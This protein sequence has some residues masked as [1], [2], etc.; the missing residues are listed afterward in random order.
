MIN[1]EES[2]T[3]KQDNSL[4][5]KIRISKLLKR[6]N[7]TSLFDIMDESSTVDIDIDFPEIPKMIFTEE[8]LDGEN[9]KN[10]NDLLKLPEFLMGDM[11][12]S[13]ERKKLSKVKMTYTPQ[14]SK[15][16]NRFLMKK[17]KNLSLKGKNINLEKMNLKNLNIYQSKNKNNK[18]KNSSKYINEDLNNI[19]NNNLIKNYN[20]YRENNFK[21]HNNNLKLLANSKSRWSDLFI[22][23]RPKNSSVIQ[24]NIY[25]DDNKNNS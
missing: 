3:F 5:N 8:E 13:S 1:P 24:K 6:E 9:E 25:I 16:N 14:K 7:P 21:K 20:S 2:I 18:Y 11:D 10:L 23:K 19:N 17:D 12:Y 22:K 4:G 15:E